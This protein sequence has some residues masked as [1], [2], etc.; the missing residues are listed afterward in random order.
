MIKEHEQP[1]VPKGSL[2]F[3]REME[4]EKD[5]VDGYPATD[6]HLNEVKGRVRQCPACGERNYL[7]KKNERPQRD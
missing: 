3:S 2:D 4:M 6:V 7:K 5:V 1:I